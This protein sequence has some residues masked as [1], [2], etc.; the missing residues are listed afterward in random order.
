MKL[1]RPLPL[2]L[3]LYLYLSL[4]A[5]ETEQNPNTVPLIRPVRYT[6]IEQQSSVRQRTFTGTAQASLENTLS[7]RVAG[8]LI[9]RPVKVGQ[10][11]KPGELIAALDPTDYEVA[12]KEAQA[13]L[14]SAAA[15]ARNARANYQRAQGLYENRNAAKSDLDV[16]RAQFES[17]RAGVNL[18]KQRLHA[19][20]LQLSY[21][22]LKSTDQCAVAVV[23]VKK[24]ENVAAG[25]PVVRLNCGDQPEVLVAVPD[26]FIDKVRVGQKVTIIFS[27]LEGRHFQGVITEVGVSSTEAATTFPVTTRLLNPDPAIR[28]GMAADVTFHSDSLDARFIVPSVAV[29]EDAAGRFVFILEPADEGRYKAR[30]RAV[31]IGALASKGLVIESGLQAGELIATAGVRRIAEGQWVTLLGNVDH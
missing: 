19:A 23:F 26:V 15:E 24:N 17:A 22:E 30:R 5:C 3:C 21:S 25:T 2:I 7:F 27:A 28:S 12:V 29:G 1:L 20:R 9:T 16:A 31:T 14:A 18:A 10:L 4:S 11:V 6:K 13:G 8:T